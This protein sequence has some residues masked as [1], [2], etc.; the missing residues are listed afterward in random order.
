MRLLLPI[1]LGLL[2]VVIVLMAIAWV[3][4]R[5][6]RQGDDAVARVLARHGAGRCSEFARLL[7]R[8]PPDALPAVW[9]RIDEAVN[10]TLLDCA[11]DVKPEL[12]SALDAAAAVCP[13]RDTSRALMAARN[14]L[15]AGE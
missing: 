5:R 8:L 2:G 13:H 11:P 3:R 6:R 9:P 10:A 14:R 7:R 12:L 15:L 1:V 4:G